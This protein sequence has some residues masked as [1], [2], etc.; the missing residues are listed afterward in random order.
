MSF[1]HLH[2]HSEYSLLDGLS[3]IKKLV[4]RAVELDMPALALTDHGTMF[5]VIDFYNAATSAGIKP[6][7][8][9]ESYM[10]ARGMQERDPQQDKKSSHILLLAENEI[11]YRNLLKLASAAQLDGFYYYPRIDHDF[12]AAH[13]EGLICTSGCMSAEVPRLI[14][15]EN[16]EAARKHLDWYYEVFGP[17]RFFLELQQHDIHELDQINKML[18]DLG[19]RYEAR[20]VATNDVHYIN[21]EDARLQDILLA[22]QT[23]CVLTD[24]NRMRMSTDSFYLRTPQ[25]MQSLFGSVPGAIENTILIAERCSLD[26]GFK[27]YRLPNFDVPDGFTAE[28]YL[29]SLCEAGLQRRYG[30]R[31]ND[32]VVRQR[33]DYELGIIHQM[34]FDTYFLIVWDLCRYARNQ[35][36][37]YNARGSAAGSIVAYTLDITL[38]DPIEHGLIFERFLNPGRISMPDIDLDFRDDRRAEMLEYTARKYGDDKVAQIITFGTLG[39]R[40][41]IR[42]VGRVMDIPLSEVDRVAKLIPNIPGKPVTI[43]E[44][45]ED[46]PDFKRL[47]DSEAYLK[48]LIDTASHMEGVVRNAGTHAAGVIITDQPIIN[49]IPLHRPTGSSSEETPIKTVTQFE[50]TTV[51]SLG[52]LKVDFL[53]L[54]TLSIMARACDLICARHRIDYN[55]DNIPTDDPATYELL[56][57]GETAGVFQVEGSGM[58]R[59]LMQM[60]PKELANVIAMVALFRPG[61]MDFIPGYIRR[62]HGEEAVTYRHPALEPIFKETFGY[63]VYQ[64][65]LMFAVMN[66]AGYTAPEADDLRKAV[67][68]KLKDKLLKHRQK[69]VSGAVQNGI[70]EET[71]NAIFDDWEEFARYGF[72][73]AHAADYGVIAVQTAYLKLHYPVEYMTALLSVTKNQTEKVALYVADC[74]RMGLSVEA[75]DINA[76]GWDFTIEDCPDESAPGGCKAVIRF[77][78]GAVKNVGQGPVDAILK[79][80]A[81]GPFSDLNDFAKRVDQRLVGKRA[82]ESLIKVGALDRFGPRQ[83]L[84]GAVD[85]IMSVS[86]SHF[87]AAESGQ[88]SLFGAHT[89][90]NEEIT[91]PIVNGEINRR[92]I[93]NWEREL[94]GLYVS[95]HPLSPY[96]EEL[97]LAVSHFSG[98]L[99]EASPSEKVRVA[100]MITRIRNHVTKTGKSMGFVTVEDIQGAVELVVFP[101]TWEKFSDII[102]IDRIVVV[103]GRVDAEGAEPKVLVD[104]I[105][106]D[107]SITTSIDPPTRVSAGYLQESDESDPSGENNSHGGE[108]LNVASETRSPSPGTPAIYA[109]VGVN[110]EAEESLEI[111][112][113]DPWDESQ[114]FE[115]MWNDLDTWG[116]DGPPPQDEHLYGRPE[117]PPEKPPARAKHSEKVTAVPEKLPVTERKAEETDP[118]DQPA[119]TPTPKPAYTSHPVTTASPAGGGANQ[120]EDSEQAAL[121]PFILSPVSSDGESVNMITV[122]MRT[123]GDHTRDV[124]RMRRIHG[125]ASS[126]PGSDRFAI[127]VFERN[128]GYLIEFPNLTTHLCSEL[129]TKL[130]VVVGSENVHID[131]VTF[132]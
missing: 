29:K 52:L 49:Y 14:Q 25:E 129:I 113:G 23:G 126:Y 13:S 26:L 48:E 44:A 58:R 56:G 9:I 47:Y 73:K 53:G 104:N 31:A 65:Q 38:V 66:L 17:D 30:G 132:Q 111:A 8:G 40:A 125:I 88:M 28:S 39:A 108:D 101:K 76:S 120:Q 95:D 114:A 7:I 55:L 15:Q 119:P 20:F 99:S 128:R 97:T 90:I 102:E 83:S 116:P 10:A 32:P 115:M 4:K 12:L 127:H 42:D 35:G 106:T 37:W 110:A 72:N 46:I 6:I 70:V 93:L 19:K 107:L 54:A 75:P 69:F 92:E 79:S 124:L 123:S 1:V 5:G 84:L 64:E 89:G 74:R 50:M 67:S 34:G 51:D 63:P 91:L 131:P 122:V 21:R 82:L 103:E 96:M 80:R 27:G 77:G 3:N 78:L 112:A 24:P 33:L 86:N 11:G 57:R 85:I 94:I 109:D 16:L 105:T 81:E 2:V 68:K 71:A 22:I 121:P 41:A 87:R 45:L 18:I 62:M 130:N 43:K 100:G 61:P 59:W 98:Q 117:I 118:A 60:K 36:I